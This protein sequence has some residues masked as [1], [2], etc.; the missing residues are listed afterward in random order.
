[1][2]AAEGRRVFELHRLPAQVEPRTTGLATDTTA[3]QSSRKP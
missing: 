2:E 3:G 1:L